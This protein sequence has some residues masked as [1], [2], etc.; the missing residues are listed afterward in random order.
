M[1]IDFGINFFFFFGI[2]NNFF[3]SSVGME[4][5]EEIRLKDFF[6]FSLSYSIYSVCVLYVF[7]YYLCLLMI[8]LL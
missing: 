7:M 6:I 5:E 3:W 1:C 8:F 2:I 4:E